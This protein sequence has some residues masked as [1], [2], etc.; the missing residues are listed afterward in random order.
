MAGRKVGKK[1]PAIKERKCPRCWRKFV[2]R[3]FRKRFCNVLCRIDAE[4]A[5]RKK[6]RTARSVRRRCLVCK[7]PYRPIG[8]QNTCLGDTCRRARTLQIQANFRA[9]HRE[10]YRRYFRAVYR[11]PQ[12]QAWL[13]KYQKTH[14][15]RL[16]YNSRRWNALHPDQVKATSGRSRWRRAIREATATG[17]SPEIRNAAWWWNKYQRSGY[18]EKHF[19]ELKECQ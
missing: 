15:V 17:I 2:S 4:K 19:K 18:T 13:K 5:R 11:T 7:K 1:K 8:R 16:R 3:C 6:E 10:R 14:R 12:H 9:R